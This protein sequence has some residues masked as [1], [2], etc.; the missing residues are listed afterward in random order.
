VGVNVFVA[1]GVS[2]AVGVND[3]TAI[4]CFASS[5]RAMDVNVVFTFGSGEGVRLGVG[6]L[7]G[8]GVRV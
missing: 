5:V 1:V 8:E 6:V 2:D 7:L 4:A 3:N